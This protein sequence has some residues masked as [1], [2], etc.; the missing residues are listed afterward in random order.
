MKG[1]RIKERNIMRARKWIFALLC[2]LLWAA[3][4]GEAFAAEPGLEEQ[5]AEKSGM[6]KAIES[7]DKGTRAMLDQWGVDGLG[8]GGLDG[9]R[10]FE[11]ICRLVREKLT[12]PLKACGALLGILLLCRLASAMGQ[13]EPGQAVG[14]IGAAACGVVAAPHMLGLLSLCTATAESASAFLLASVPAYTAL[15]T[16]SGSPAAGGGY[17]FLTLGVGNL[18]PVLTSGLLLPLLR[19]FLALSAAGCVSGLAVQKLA[20]SLYSFVKWLL[21]LAVTLFSGVLSVQTILNTQ[22]DAAGSKAVKLVASSAIPIVGGALGDAMGAIQ[23]SVHVVRSGAGA[24]GMLA[25]LCLFAPAMIEASLWAGVCT[26]GQLTADLC[27]VPASPLLGA[28]ANSA[29]LVLAALASL[30]VVCLT[31]TG[32]VL[33]AK[34]G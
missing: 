26:V 20:A 3:S 9:G 13:G 1:N 12:G 31:C 27:G 24:F 21:L 6:T 25:A 33:F 18:L 29:K 34:G 8:K 30:C 16:A 17:S 11:S 15:L 14:V 32:V 10:V 2:L 4:P 5:I 7:L 19:I 28:C 23:G 22:L